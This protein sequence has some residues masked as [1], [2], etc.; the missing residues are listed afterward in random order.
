MSTM[1]KDAPLVKQVKGNEKIPVSDGSGM[2]RAVT[3]EQLESFVGNR[4]IALELTGN[5]KMVAI[6]GK[7]SEFVD[8]Q[9]R[10]NG[11]LVFEFKID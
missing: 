3:V 11:E 9:I 6:Y 10:E 7:N 8:G 1:I 4:E 5:G 2:P